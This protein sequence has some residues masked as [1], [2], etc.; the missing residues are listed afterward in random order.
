MT[1]GTDPLKLFYCYAREDKVFRDDLDRH[2]SG[3]KREGLL[4]T[5]HDL[6]ITAGEEWEDAI[7]THLNEADII[8]L[9]ISPH[10]MASDY[11][12]GKEMARALQR[13]ER[14]EA[15]VMPI[16]I[17]PVD[18]TN[19]PFSKIN[20]LP[21][22]AIA[23]TRWEDRD[24]AFE[25]AGR[26][27]RAVVEKL[28]ERFKQ[29]ELQNS[30]KQA[31]LIQYNENLALCEEAIRNDPTDAVAH[32]AK[33]Y[34]LVELDRMQEA[35]D[36]LD[37][38]IRLDPT[39]ASA[40]FNKGKA[41][42]VLGRLDEALVTLNKSIRLTRLR[43]SD[44]WKMPIIYQ[45][46]AYVL[47][48]LSRNE[49]ALMAFQETIRRDPTVSTSHSGISAVFYALN[50]F[51]EALKTAEEALRIDPDNT[52]AYRHKGNALLKL[53]RYKEAVAAFDRFIY[54]DQTSAEVYNNKGVALALQGQLQEAL[55]TYDKAI[56]LD[57]T[58][59]G[60][61]QRRQYIIDALYNND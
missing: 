15:R 39:Y 52:A 48:A 19:A 34:V 18:W 23:V 9:L 51:E 21:S 49:E 25:D 43:E 22:N 36:P 29:K 50:R 3:L 1:A 61:K 53:E 27:I 40:Y 14:G 60:M 11:C 5:W 8:A 26:G 10:F 28:V 30:K 59:A 47:S 42:A 17:R 2:L 33:G 45:T 58:N 32:G 44:S 13:H 31:T 46:K 55:T 37:E 41:L 56:Q 6:M 57:P 24:S 4:T 12:Y 7:N 20:L 38:A 35:L 54:I 16:L